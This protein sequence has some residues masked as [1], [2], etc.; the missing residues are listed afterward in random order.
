MEEQNS[1]SF[2]AITRTAFVCTLELLA[3]PF[4]LSVLDPSL[5]W[6]WTP[7]ELLFVAN[8]LFA[9]CG[10]RFYSSRTSH[11]KVCA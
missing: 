10:A 8:W 11:Q 4:V 7:K 5:E 1:P 2:L 6:T 9:V 3:I